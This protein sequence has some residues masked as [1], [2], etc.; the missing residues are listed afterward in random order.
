MPQSFLRKQ[1]RHYSYIIKEFLTARTF[2]YWNGKGE[3]PLSFSFSPKGS[4]SGRNL[5][6]Y[7]TT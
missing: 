1:R 2:Y 7:Q 6:F 3:A 4:I 5:A